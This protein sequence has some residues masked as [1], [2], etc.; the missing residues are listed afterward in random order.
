MK[1]FIL[2]AILASSGCCLFRDERYCHRYDSPPVI[3]TPPNV[4]P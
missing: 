1:T 4:N 3:V 2:L